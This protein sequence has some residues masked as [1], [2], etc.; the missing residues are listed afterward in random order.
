MSYC[1][2]TRVHLAWRFYTHIL[3]LNVICIV[4]VKREAF[5]NLC[6]AQSLDCVSIPTTDWEIVLSM[7]LEKHFWVRSTKYVFNLGGTIKGLFLEVVSKGFLC[8]LC[9]FK[10]K[11]SKICS[12]HEHLLVRRLWAFVWNSRFIVKENNLMN[13]SYI[14]WL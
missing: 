3:N 4:V 13:R 8:F 5:M 1:W 10:V 6:L 11:N 14:T 9:V 2:F 7:W 12:K